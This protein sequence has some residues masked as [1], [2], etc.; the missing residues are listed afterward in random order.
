MAST[1]RVGDQVRVPLGRRKVTGTISEDRGRLGVRGQHIYQ[2]LVPDDPFEPTPYIYSE[3][4]I[5]AIRDSPDANS[6][7][8][9]DKTI[10]YLTHGGLISIL[11]ASTSGGGNHSRV[12]L[13]TDSLGNVTHTFIKERG[14][15]GGETIPLMATHDERILAAKRGEVAALLRSFGLDDSQVDRVI[16]MVGT[17]PA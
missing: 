9:L 3:D 15:V 12:W 7:M 6:R 13:R 10:D 17:F 16:R 14:L 2:I 1:F 5:E 8:D 4:E 11:R